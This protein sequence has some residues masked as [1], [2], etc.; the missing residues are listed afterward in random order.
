M[1]YCTSGNIIELYSDKEENTN[2]ASTHS[3]P[4]TSPNNENN[5]IGSSN[6]FYPENLTFCVQARGNTT[7]RKL[8]FY[9][10]IFPLD[11]TFNQ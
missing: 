2:N 8:K 4:S 1:H 6:V 3:R 9:P 11:H 7:L 10:N 5:S